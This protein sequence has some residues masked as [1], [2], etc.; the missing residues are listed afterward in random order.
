VI[1]HRVANLLDTTWPAHRLEVLVALDAEGAQTT[2]E[3]LDALLQPL[4]R[5]HTPI[6]VLVGDA[7]GGKA[8]ALNA[9]VREATGD[10]LLLADSRQHFEPDTLPQLAAALGDST[11]GAA[12][13]AL[14]LGGD[15]R[16]PVHRYW[17]MEKRL[18]HDE[19]R[20]HSAI[21]VTGAVYA[22]RRALWPVIPAGTLLDDVYLPMAL[23]LQGH[24]IAFVPEARATDVRAF[25]ARAEQGRKARTLTG[26]L[27][28]CRLLPDVL[29][30]SRNP[31]WAQFVVHKLLRLA[32]PVLATCSAL[33]GLLLLLEALR[34]WPSPTMGVL[35]ALLAVVLLVPQARRLAVALLRWGWAMQ[36][37][38]LTALVNGARGRWRVWSGGGAAS[39]NR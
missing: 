16:S 32:T 17:A 1:A 6:R 20:L 38:V 21:G 7:P 34:R 8:C 23:V 26:V 25:D 4:A 19:A 27:Q 28:L 36:V 13:G 31:V 11:I 24:R 15:A 5:A 33:G 3:A 30:P 18:R 14:T 35:G 37:A 9:A 10:L 39:Q 22:T 29:S 2:P 12:S